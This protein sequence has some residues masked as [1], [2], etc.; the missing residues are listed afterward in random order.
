MKV[1]TNLYRN[2]KWEKTLDGS[3]DSSSTLIFIFSASDFSLNDAGYR[4][5]LSK[6][7]NAIITG[8]STAGEIY[9]DELHD[10]SLSI[11]IAQF[12]KT[13]I[14]SKWIQVDKYEDSY[15][16]GSN[17]ANMFDPKGLKSVFVLGDGLGVNG[18]E[19]VRGVNYVFKGKTIATGGMA[20]DAGKFEKTWVFIDKEPLSNYV[21]AIGFYGESVNVDYASEGGWSQF[22]LERVVTE[23]DEQTNTI[24]TLDHKPAL[25]LYKEYM[26]EHAKDLPSSAL[27]FPF[28]VIDNDRDNKIR[29]IWGANEE[30]Q[31]VQLFGDV[32]NGDKI[33]FLKGS[34]RFIISGAQKAACDL[35]LAYGKTLL[36][37]AVSCM[38]R[39]AVLQDRTE[40]EVE[41]VKDSLGENVSQ[42]GF[43]S[44]G[45]LSP[46]TSGKCGML[47]QTMTLTLISES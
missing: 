26:G 28:L 6:F 9:E 22:G 8:C 42:V 39:R 34:P 18:S 32:K 44:Y 23:C 40:D 10:G 31:S 7:P 38:G 17:L 35:D 24:Y 21:S 20:S 25:E 36:S 19:L 12:E 30:N 33:V 45:E 16:A 1:Q 11:A 15:E 2:G 5:L 13:Q 43:Y 29:A 14:V 37:I 27:Q 46:R 3:L 47:N 41:V 4:E